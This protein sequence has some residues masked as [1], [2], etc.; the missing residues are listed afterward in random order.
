VT[1]SRP[2]VCSIS[3][4]DGERLTA[5]A[6]FV[7]LGLEQHQKCIYL[8]SDDSEEET[9]R[10]LRAGGVDVPAALASEAL[11]ITTPWR[12]SLRRDGYDPYRLFTFW[13]QSRD[14]AHRRGF[15]GMRGV[16]HL[17]ESIRRETHA[18]GWLEYEDKLTDFTSEGTAAF[19]CQF[20]RRVVPASAMR[21]AVQAHSAIILGSWL[22]DEP[23]D[24]FDHGAA[25]P[26]PMAPEVARLLEA[27]RGF[28]RGTPKATDRDSARSASWNEFARFSQRVRF[29]ELSSA[30]VGEIQAS[31]L[32]VM[33]RADQGMRLL[34]ARDIDRET[35][36]AQLSATSQTMRRT[37]FQLARI[38]SLG[39]RLPPAPQP[40]T[41]A[42]AIEA[43]CAIAAP[44]LERHEIRVVLELAADAPP[45]SADRM[46]FEHV[47]LALLENAIESLAGSLVGER[48]IEI[49]TQVASSEQ[50]LI[51]VE[52]SGPGIPTD[53]ASRIFEPFYTTKPFHMG[54]G[55]S[56]ARSICRAHGG[57]MWAEHG[58]RFHCALPI[59][60]RE[61][62]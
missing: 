1:V 43:V 36:R 30:L 12:L 48:R 37:A 5:A 32:E 56:I 21:A 42:E 7:R 10:A 33:E 50:V 18:P 38:R 55:L 61:G 58:A 6:A 3:S 15:T 25:P 53:A 59:T 23:L 24:A 54:L 45:V 22:C 40:F 57:D 31:V 52:D 49:R 62:T 17:H 26:G 27:L 60:E 39:R 19:L 9:Y 4:D 44:E 2:H 8:V 13:K 28:E 41:I 47:I 14:E 16:G 29:A 35:V 20:D 51:I 34:A 46:Q 11:Q